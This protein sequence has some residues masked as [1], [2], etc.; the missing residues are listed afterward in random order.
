MQTGRGRDGFQDAFELTMQDAG[1]ELVSSPVHTAHLA[2]V[3]R[4]A[5]FVDERR[6]RGLDGSEVCQSVTYFAACRAR[7]QRGRRHD[8]AKP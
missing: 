3:T 8:E 6:Q 7:T 2:Q 5:P 4:K 1:N